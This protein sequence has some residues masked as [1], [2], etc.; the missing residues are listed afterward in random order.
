MKTSTTSIKTMN[1]PNNKPIVGEEN[2][3]QKLK[4]EIMKEGRKAYRN[5]KEARSCPY[6]HGSTFELWWIKGF[7]KADPNW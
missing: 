6:S 2:S 3:H 1:N 5:D 4:Q 7:H